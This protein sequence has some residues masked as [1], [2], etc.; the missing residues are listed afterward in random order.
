MATRVKNRVSET[1]SDGQPEAEKAA[2]FDKWASMRLVV[3]VFKVRGISPLLQNNPAKFI[4]TDGEE[5]VRAGKKKYDDE[6]E[7]ELRVYKDADG[8]FAHPSEAFTKALVRASRGKKIGKA[9]APVM[10]QSGVFAMQPYCKIL[11]HKGKPLTEYTIDRRSVVINKTK[12]VL[13]CRPCWPEWM[14]EV[15]LEIDVSLVRVNNVKDIL[16]LAARYPGIGD[17]RPEK[18]GAF[19]RFEVL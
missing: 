19:G 17:Y 14:M 2:E 1:D 13:R 10:L 3:E 18:G 6:E 9:S 8:D 11:D 5:V 12:R 15:A 4:G 16:T 7:A